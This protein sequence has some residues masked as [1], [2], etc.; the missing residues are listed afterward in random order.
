MQTLATRVLELQPGIDIYEEGIYHWFEEIPAWAGD[1]CV[2]TDKFRL[3][4]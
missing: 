1:D 3:N 4:L 2:G